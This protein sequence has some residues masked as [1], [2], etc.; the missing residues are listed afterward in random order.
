MSEKK[1]HFVSGPSTEIVVVVVVVVVFFFS[2]HLLANS[3][4]Y[5]QLLPCG[6]PGITD[7]PI[8]RTPRYNGHPDN[9]DTPL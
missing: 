7:N 8:I 2:F 9:T 1:E 3:A 4:M 6:H 5:R